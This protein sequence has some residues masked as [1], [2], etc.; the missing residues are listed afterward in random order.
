MRL[1]NSQLVIFKQYCSFLYY[2]SLK[3][4]I[5]IGF[6][7]LT[8]NS[9]YYFQLFFVKMDLLSSKS[10]D[11]FRHLFWCTPPINQPILERVPFRCFPWQKVH[12]A[13]IALLSHHRQVLLGVG[14]FNFQFSR[15]WHW[16]VHSIKTVELNLEQ[17]C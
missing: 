14:I 11:Y 15:T 13:F 2:F 8:W 12:T 17:S 5:C 10:T 4:H 16:D 3:T 6:Y 9:K 1:K 7:S